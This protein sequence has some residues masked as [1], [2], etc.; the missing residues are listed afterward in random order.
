VLI[1]KNWQ[2]DLHIGYKEMILQLN[3]FMTLGIVTYQFVGI[4]GRVI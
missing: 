3:P 4:D 1:S 2:N